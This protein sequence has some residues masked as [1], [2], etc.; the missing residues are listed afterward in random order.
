MIYRHTIESIEKYSFVTKVE[1]TGNFYIK[2]YYK[3]NNVE[4][5]ESISRRASSKQ[6]VSVIKKIKRIADKP[7]SPV[8]RD[9]MPIY[10]V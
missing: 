3:V 7:P 2:I 10:I 5:F 9:E 8:I 6:L 4:K 1:E